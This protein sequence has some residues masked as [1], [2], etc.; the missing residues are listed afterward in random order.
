MKIPVPTEPL[1]MNPAWTVLKMQMPAQSRKTPWKCREYQDSKL[2]AKHGWLV[3][4]QRTQLSVTY[5]RKQFSTSGE[6]TTF[7]EFLGKPPHKGSNSRTIP[8]HSLHGGK[9][10]TL[11]F[12]HLVLV[13]TIVLLSGG[14]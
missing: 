2:F 11:G 1:K 4:R 9:L 7:K 14:V 10:R 12:S 3:K 5:P 6:A 8:D 13:Y